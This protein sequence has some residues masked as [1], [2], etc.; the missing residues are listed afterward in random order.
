MNDLNND[1]INNI[2][3]IWIIYNFLSDYGYIFFIAVVIFFSFKKKK[4]NM[5]ENLNS[6]KYDM[7]EDLK[8]D[9]EHSSKHSSKRDFTSGTDLNNIELEIV[10]DNKE[11]TPL[12][13]IDVSGIYSS[14]SEFY[15]DGLIF[16][17]KNEDIWVFR[18][19]EMVSEEENIY[20][21][22]SPQNPT[23]FENSENKI[24]YYD[25]INIVELEKY[26][27]YQYIDYGQIID[28]GTLYNTFNKKSTLTVKKI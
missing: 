23:D 26:Y 8:P 18:N 7:I 14:T 17:K 15:N 20:W 24:V 11:R 6:P 10:Y 12:V 13:N 1:V 25:S 3:I 9:S 28:N 19:K 21:V 22:L 4:L 16:K 5:F 2:N 27:V